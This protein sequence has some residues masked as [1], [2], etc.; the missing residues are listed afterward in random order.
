[1]FTEWF[2]FSLDVDIAGALRQAIRF[3]DHCGV[4][5]THKGFGVWVPSEK[6]DK[7]VGIVRPEDAAIFLGKRFEESGL[8]LS[9]GKD[10]VNLL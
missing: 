6:Y 2:P 10:A 1:M 4:V 8:P 3:S 5:K 7:A 9:C